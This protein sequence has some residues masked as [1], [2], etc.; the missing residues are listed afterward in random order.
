MEAA[1]LEIA[2]KCFAYISSDALKDGHVQLFERLDR[3]G[4]SIRLQNYLLLENGAVVNRA[5]EDGETALHKAVNSGNEGIVQLL[6]EHRA[7]V[8]KADKVVYLY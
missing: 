2:E 3:P 5:N 6:L 8:N 1:N 7:D 4:A